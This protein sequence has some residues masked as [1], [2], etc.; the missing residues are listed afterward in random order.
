MPAQNT[1]PATDTTDEQY[2]A[3][4]R[5]LVDELGAVVIQTGGR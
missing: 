2:A 1:A 3:A 4:M 5:L